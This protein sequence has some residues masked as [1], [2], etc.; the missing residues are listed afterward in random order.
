MHGAL[1]EF[2]AKNES[3]GGI[4]PFEEVPNDTRQRIA[5]DGDEILPRLHCTTVHGIVS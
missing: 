1:Y 2:D 3:R 5:D 4:V